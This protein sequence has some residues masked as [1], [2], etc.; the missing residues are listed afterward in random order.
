MLF[1]FMWAEQ[2]CRKSDLLT[3][4]I[5]F[6]CNIE[7]FDIFIVNNKEIADLI[8]VTCCTS[9]FQ[10]CFL[11]RIILFKGPALNQQL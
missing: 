7:S 3:N 4:F 9:D 5:I 11:K 8:S 2:S 6:F 1:V 10:D